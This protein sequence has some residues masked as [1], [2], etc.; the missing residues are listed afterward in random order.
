MFAQGSMSLHFLQVLELK[1]CIG[2]LLISLIE[3][4]SP[5][6]LLVSKVSYNIICVAYPNLTPTKLG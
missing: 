5:E 2:N 6:A 4:N 1:H 3:E